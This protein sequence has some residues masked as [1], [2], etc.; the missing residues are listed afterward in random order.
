MTKRGGAS[1]GWAEPQAVRREGRGGNTGVSPARGAKLGPTPHAG[2][3]AG[4]ASGGPGRALQLW[5]GPAARPP[6]RERRRP[7][8]AGKPG[9]RARETCG[10]AARA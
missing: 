10:L 6:D 2:P 4:R 9:L 7:P 1:L 8:S 3:H 5:A